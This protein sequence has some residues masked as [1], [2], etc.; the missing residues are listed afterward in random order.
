MKIV[1]PSVSLLWITK[2]PEQMI[3]QSGRTCYKSEDKI[4]EES[5]GKFVK[6]LTKS[7]HHAMIEHATASFRII[8][9]RGIC[10]SEDT[11]VLTQDGWKFF[12]EVTDE[13]L[14]LTKDDCGN[15]LYLPPTKIVVKKYKGDM[16]LFENTELSLLVTPNH[17]MWVFDYNKRS[18]LTKVWKFLRADKMSNGAYEFDVSGKWHGKSIEVI[19]VPSTT[20][21]RG[22]YTKEYDGRLFDSKLF[23][24]L[25]GLW[26]TDGSISPKGKDSGRRITI[27]QTKS[28]VRERIEYLL[29]TLNLD[30]TKFKNDYRITCLPLWF[31]LKEWFIKREDYKKSTY[32][33]IPKWIKELN[34]VLLGSFLEGVVLGDGG[35][36]DSGTMIYSSSPAFCKGLVEIALKVGKCA[37]IRESRP[38]GHI[39]KWADGRESVCKAAYVVNIKDKTHIHLDSRRDENSIGKKYPYDGVV[40]CA[41]LPK[42][43][44]LFV[45]RNGKA[46]WCGNTHEIVRHRL[47]SYAQESTRYCNYS[48]DKF[49]N[50]CTFIQPQDLSYPQIM[51]WK[52]ACEN[53]EYSYFDLLASG[54]TPQIARAVLPNC[55]KTEIVM[56]A[57]LRE[58]RHFIK[59]RGSQAAHPQIRTVAYGVWLILNEH[60][61]NVFGDLAPLSK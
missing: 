48:K 10:Y 7:G 27:T 33:A 11:E 9:D 54:C 26:A 50:E 38:E 59:L 51:K 22:I 39:K 44:K 18:P 31:K 49:G 47:A 3:E 52:V 34:T 14:F 19:D 12:T 25:L 24:E 61:P 35:K 57:N 55:L 32:I 53:A 28:Q 5:A 58:W 17:N 45:M 1:S 37:S 30:Y 15:L 56:M 4:T 60:A 21:P 2:N 41:E 6:M 13:D 40:Y 8:T 42:Y 36:Y 43:H 46:A 23:L 29:K 16:L 20:V